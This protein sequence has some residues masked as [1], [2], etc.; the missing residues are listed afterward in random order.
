VKNPFDLDQLSQSVTRNKP[1]RWFNQRSLGLRQTSQFEAPLEHSIQGLH[2]GP[3]VGRQ[4][5]FAH[6]GHGWRRGTVQGTFSGRL[7]ATWSRFHPVKR[8][9]RRL[10]G[11]FPP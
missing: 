1:A 6:S 11:C 3:F 9:S 10:F 7:V 4:G 8:R 5:R 2:Q